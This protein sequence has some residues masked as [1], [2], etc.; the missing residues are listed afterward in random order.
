MKKILAVSILLLTFSSV[1]LAQKDA[2]AKDIL[3]KA[4]KAFAQAGDISAN[5]SMSIKDP[6][7]NSS[8]AFEGQIDL[9]GNKFHI[10]VP[11]Y[12]IWF[13]GKTQWHLQ[14]Q[15]EEVNISEPSKE[16]VQALNPNLIFEL[17]KKGANYKYMGEK[18]NVKMQQVQEIE[19][20][21]P[22]KDSQIKKI[23]VQFA[24]DTLLPVMIHLSY[25]NL[26]ENIIY[27]N[28]YQTKQH[29]SDSL[30]VFDESNYPDAEIIDLR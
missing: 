13:D 8:E 23:T 1:G 7:S 15:W 30:F 18:T 16:E 27:I 12:E 6:S 24:A 3:D 11:D 28:K 10:L 17:Y 14:R 25:N 2:K 26:L 29:L 19:L 21:I 20:T 9:K 22:G 4:S 5:F